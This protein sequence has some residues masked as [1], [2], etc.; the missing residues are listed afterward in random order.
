[1]VGLDDSGLQAALPSIR[2]GYG[3]KDVVTPLA[4]VDLEEVKRAADRL[5]EPSV[6]GTCLLAIARSILSAEP[7][8]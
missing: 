2:T 5:R 8:K 1:M 4:R 6:R 7:D 3:L